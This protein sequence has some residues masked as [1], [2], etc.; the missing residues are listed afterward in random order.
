VVGVADTGTPD[1]DGVPDLAALAVV[2]AVVPTEPEDDDGAPLLRWALDEAA[3]VPAAV[4]E[5]RKEQP[6]RESTARTAEAARTRAVV[7]RS[8]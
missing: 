4:T 8:R 2:P 6:A 5:P 7:M 3:E 1:G